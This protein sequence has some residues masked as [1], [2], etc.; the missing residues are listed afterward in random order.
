MIIHKLIL[1]YVRRYGRW[2][3]GIKDGLVGV[4]CLSCIRDQWS[5]EVLAQ[6]NSCEK[7]NSKYC[8]NLIV[9]IIALRAAIKRTALG[10]RDYF[11][12]E[13]W[14]QHD[15]RMGEDRSVRLAADCQPLVRK[16]RCRQKNKWSCILL[17]VQVIRC[18]IHEE[19]QQKFQFGPRILSK[20][21]LCNCVYLIGCYILLLQ[22]FVLKLNALH[23][24][25]FF[26]I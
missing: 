24:N 9:Q 11:Y 25:Y 17:P 16:V 26:C 4:Q 13:R 23:R 3:S 20:Y 14:T 12:R 22:V 8:N 6:Q 15:Y 1:I 5:R 21:V 10:G 18:I 7:C 19:G 2:C